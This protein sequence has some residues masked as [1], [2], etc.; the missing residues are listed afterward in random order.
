MKK[1]TLSYD[2]SLVE[3]LTDALSEHPLLNRFFMTHDIG[4][5]TIKEGANVLKTYVEEQPLCDHC[6]GLHA[7]KQATLG[8]QPVLQ[9]YQG[10]IR[11][12]YQSC[13]YHQAQQAQKHHQRSLNALYLPKTVLDAS[14]EDFRQDNVQRQVLYQKMMKILHR[15]KLKEPTPGLYLYGSYQVGKTYALAALANEITKYGLTVAMTYFPDWSR[16]LKSAMHEGKL[17]SRIAAFKSVDVLILDDLAGESFS[18][19]LRDEVLGP[20]L[21]H[22]LLDQK[23]TFF[24]SNIDLKNL[25]PCYVGENTDTQKI[26]AYRIVERIKAL[27]EPVKL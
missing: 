27:S 18:E 15:I 24:S 21:Q 17:E 16:E 3:S 2:P 22:R 8:H 1:P 13:P 9:Y 12:A 19:W 14:L 6:P 23:L 25:A 10:T 11:L 5:E 7:C 4:Y 20:I 26:K